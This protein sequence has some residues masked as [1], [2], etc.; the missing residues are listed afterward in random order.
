MAQFV[1]ERGI[2]LHLDGARVFNAAVALDVPVTD[3]TAPVDTVAFCLSKGLSAPVGSLL[4]GPAAFIQEARRVRKILGGGMRQ[5]GVLAAAGLVALDEMVDRLAEDHAN[6]RTLAEA[7]ADA[8]GIDLDMATVQT[9][10]VLFDVAATGLSAPAFCEAMKAEG[11]LCSPRDTGAAVRMVTHR[12][13]TADDAKAAG[14]AVN[15]M[16][17]KRVASRAAR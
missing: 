4:C 1:H 13:V 11:V 7:I 12:H 16:L 17:S 8:P 2:P 5:A 3:L 6:A 10:I 9:N 15:R 14:E